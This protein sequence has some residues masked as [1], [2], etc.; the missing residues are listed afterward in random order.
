M[1]A[2]EIIQEAAKK[3]PNVDEWENDRVLIPVENKY[4]SRTLIVDP[5]PD[6]NYNYHYIVEFVICTDIVG[7]R[8][9]DFYS[10][11]GRRNV[12]KDKE[13]F[14]AREM[15]LADVRNKL[16]PIATL[17]QAV[18]VILDE[19]KGSQAREYCKEQ[20]PTLLEKSKEAL[21]YIRTLNINK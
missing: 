11:D 4:L 5:I 6:V 18:E 7:N 17:L 15:L 19:D 20:C 14:S 10:L 3:L 16:G 13:I 2:N 8:F 12:Q 21:N 9:W 1:K